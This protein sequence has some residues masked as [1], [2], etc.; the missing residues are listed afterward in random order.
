MHK[1]NM[2]CGAFERLICPG[3]G[4]F[5]RVCFQKILMPGEGM[6]SAEID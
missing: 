3:P 6:G 5:A 2:Y 1:R 4:A